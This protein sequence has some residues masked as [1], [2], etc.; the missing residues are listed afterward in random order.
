MG[1]S[2]VGIVFYFVNSSTSFS[3]SC[4]GDRLPVCLLLISQGDNVE[5]G[6]SSESNSNCSERNLLRNQ[7]NL[8]V[9]GP[10]RLRT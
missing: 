6:L 8:E 1:V 7:E 2:A 9:Q 4:F 10:G 3:A 5:P